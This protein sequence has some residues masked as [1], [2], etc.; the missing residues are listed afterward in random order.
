LSAVLSPERASQRPRGLATF[1]AVPAAAALVD[2]LLAEPPGLREDAA[3][4]ERW[5]RQRAQVVEGVGE[6][7]IETLAGRLRRHVV[8]MLESGR[9]DHG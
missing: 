2:P 1:F 5:Q 8:P 6:A 4:V 7:V 9:A 3:L